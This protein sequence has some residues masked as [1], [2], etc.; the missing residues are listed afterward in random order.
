VRGIRAALNKRG[1]RGVIFG[2]AGDAHVHV[3]PLIDMRKESW[4]S[5]VEG[6]L[7]DAVGLTASLGGTLDGEHGDGRLRTPL[8]WRVWSAEAQELFREVKNA[9]DPA[10]ILNP[11]VKIPLENQRPLGDIK[12][13]PSL[14]PLPDEARKAL[15]HVADNRAYSTFRL[16]LIPG[17]K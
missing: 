16:S 14:A 17:V 10:G 7:D 5:D 8:L 2:H 9:F 6:L 13:D 12:Y 1:V 11:G 4:R 3:N 15:D